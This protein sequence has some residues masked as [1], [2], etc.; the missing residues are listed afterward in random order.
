MAPNGVVLADT[1]ARCSQLLDFAATT[2]T[3]Y[4]MEFPD[5]LSI[6]PAQR[7]TLLIGTMDALT[8][9]GWSPVEF[10]PYPA[11]V[12]CGPGFETNENEWNASLL[13][14]IMP[15]R[16][17]L[18]YVSIR[19]EVD[20]GNSLLVIKVLQDFDC[21]RTVGVTEVSGRYDV[22]KPLFGGGW[23]TIRSVVPD[24]DE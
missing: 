16:P 15:K 18:M 1:E 3:R 2:P 7:S 12:P 22:G 14:R 21:D 17:D 11:I 24:L 23:T 6:V 5:W 9:G 20:A 10:G 8:R 13:V 19:L 4:G